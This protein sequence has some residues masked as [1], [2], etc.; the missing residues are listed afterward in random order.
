MH[1]E[2]DRDSGGI[3]SAV[4]VIAAAALWG[5]VAVAVKVLVE[6]VDFSLIAFI[7]MLLGALTVWLAWRISHRPGQRTPLKWGL[8]AA[9]GFGIALNY[10]LYTFGLRMTLASAGSIVVQSEVVFLALISYVFL[11]ESFGR[12]KILGTSVALAGVAIVTWGGQT[13]RA[14]IESQYLTGNLI[15]LAAGFFWAIYAYGQKILS[16][17]KDLLA[18]VYPIFIVASLILLP[19]SAGSL[20]SIPS[21]SWSE[22]LMLL[23]LGAVCTGVSYMLLASGMRGLTASTAGVLTTVMPVTSVALAIVLLHEPLTP[24][25]LLGA[26]MNVAGILLV[27]W[28]E[29]A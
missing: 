7:R 28:R 10:L 16:A 19:F 2:A 13:L 5:T 11:G 20:A 27:M 21:L 14:L 6:T 12:K 1:P 24:Y 29:G 18:S 26:A 15:V 3:G 25:I 17:E 9:A 8:I 22:V 4:L 23:Y